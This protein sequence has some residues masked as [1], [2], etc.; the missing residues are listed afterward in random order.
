MNCATRGFAKAVHQ[1]DIQSETGSPGSTLAA[2][3]GRPT[4]IPRRLRQE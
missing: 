1:T 4:F 2:A 3:A